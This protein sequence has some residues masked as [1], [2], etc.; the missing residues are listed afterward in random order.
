MPEGYSLTTSDQNRIE[1][2]LG[3]TPLQ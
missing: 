1:T 2:W 3:C